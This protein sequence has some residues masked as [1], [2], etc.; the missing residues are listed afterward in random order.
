MPT[1]DIITPKKIHNTKLSIPQSSFLIYAI[2]AHIIIKNI[3]LNNFGL[4]EI[5]LLRLKSGFSSLNRKYFICIQHKQGFQ[6][7]IHLVQE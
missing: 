1:N 5:V 7:Y 2:K 4:L 6:V 3:C